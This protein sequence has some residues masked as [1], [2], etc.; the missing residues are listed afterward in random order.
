MLDTVGGMTSPGY[1]RTL[2]AAWVM[3]IGVTVGAALP[4][5][6]S[7]GDDAEAGLG[8]WET[9]IFVALAA[10]FF[11]GMRLNARRRERRQ[12]EADEAT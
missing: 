4:A 3:A 8:V 9:V 10:A 2:V 5:S 7:A 1:G 12:R 11:V 6:A